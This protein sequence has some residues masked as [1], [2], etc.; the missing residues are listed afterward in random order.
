MNVPGTSQLS[1]TGIRYFRIIGRANVSVA[2]AEFS[3]LTFEGRPLRIASVTKSSMA[4]SGGQSWNCVDGDVRTDCFTAFGAVE[5]ILFDMGALLPPASIQKIVVVNRLGAGARDTLA[6]QPLQF[7]AFDMAILSTV[8]FPADTRDQYQF[9]EACDFGTFLNIIDCLKC[10]VSTYKDQVSNASSCTTCPVRNGTQTVTVWVGSNSSS[11]CVCPEGFAATA[12]GTCTACAVN[13]FREVSSALGFCTACPP[14]SSTGNK[15]AQASCN[16]C[17][18]G[19]SGNLGSTSCRPCTNCSPVISENSPPV[20]PDTTI[21]S[22]ILKSLII[23]ATSTPSP[24]T[25]PELAAISALLIVAIGASSLGCVLLV[26]GTLAFVLKKRKISKAAKL[27]HGPSPSAPKYMPMGI[28]STGRGL[29][30]ANQLLNVNRLSQMQMQMSCST[31]TGPN[32]NSI[33]G[34]IK[35]G[36]TNNMF[37]SGLSNNMVLNSGLEPILS[38]QTNQTTG[39]FSNSIGRN[40]A[41]MTQ[42]GQLPNLMNPTV[43]KKNQ[44]MGFP[45]TMNSNFSQTTQQFSLMTSIANTQKIGNTVTLMP[46]HTL[47]FESSV[48]NKT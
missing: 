18:A 26:S 21:S 7:L 36:M 14:G 40:F 5:S 10:P 27:Q 32:L 35:Y 37:N 20:V 34:S 31:P 28:S 24:A 25:A 33:T 16:F 39:S 1:G 23:T 44:S 45:R 8:S 46:R 48:I 38:G 43:F 12:P 15:T 17:V 41:P 47:Q 3:V 9:P 2:L 6:G 30:P 13:T 22:S 4:V 29:D 11:S 19:F 42:F